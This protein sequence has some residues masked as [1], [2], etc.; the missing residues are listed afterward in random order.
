MRNGREVAI[1]RLLVIVIT[2][3]LIIVI[4]YMLIH[5]CVSYILINELITVYHLW[6][7]FSR[8]V[9]SDSGTQWTTYRPLGSSVHGILQ[10][11]ILE[12]VDISFSG[13]SSWP[14]DRTH[15][16]LLCRQVLYHWATW[17]TLIYSCAMLSHFSHIWLFVTLWTVAHQAPLSMGFSRQEY[18]SGLLCPAPGDIPRIKPVS[19]SSPALAG[20]WILYH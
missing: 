17:G 10:A 19:L 13:G 16:L 14:R 5:I 15:S 20:R 11:G 18:W 8:W 2:K 9:L 6:L 4:L 1:Q 7:L 12:W 3:Y